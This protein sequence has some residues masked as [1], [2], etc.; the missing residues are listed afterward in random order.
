MEVKNINKD[1][2]KMSTIRVG[3]ITYKKGKKVFPEYE[4]FTRVEVMPV[5]KGREFTA[6]GGKFDAKYRIW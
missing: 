5:R 2:D 4:G 3:T 6:D 1:K